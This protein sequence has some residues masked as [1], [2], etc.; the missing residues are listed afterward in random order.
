MHLVETE[1]IATDTAPTLQELRVA[2]PSVLR[3]LHPLFLSASLIAVGQ[4]LC[5]VCWQVLIG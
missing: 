2:R 5:L 1:S 3:L 4:V